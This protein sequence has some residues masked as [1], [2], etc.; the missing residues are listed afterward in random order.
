LGLGSRFGFFE[1]IRVKVR[2]HVRVSDVVRIKVMIQANAAIASMIWGEWLQI[3]MRTG[4]LH[5]QI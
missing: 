5:I 4:I 3:C 2:V 1:L